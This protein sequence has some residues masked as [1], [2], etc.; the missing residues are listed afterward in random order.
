MKRY[1][2]FKIFGLILF[3]TSC[4]TSMSPTEVHSLLPRLTS[5]TFYTQVLA[6]K[7]IEDGGCKLLVA[8]RKFRAPQG[9]SISSDLRNGAK[10]IDEW[11]SID[12]GNAYF[13]KNYAWISLD[14]SESKTQLAVE[15][16]TMLCD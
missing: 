11:V 6:Q 14:G 10:G 2:Y 9:I 1:A 13:L 4:A 7:A 16:G 12:G 5:A 3:F 15:F 8:E